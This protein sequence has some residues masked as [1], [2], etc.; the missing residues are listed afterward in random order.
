MK[1]RKGEGEGEGERERGERKRKRERERKK[2]RKRERERERERERKK[3]R[4]RDFVISWFFRHSLSPLSPSMHRIPSIV[5][6]SR[7]KCAGHSC[8]DACC[9]FH[10]SA[11]GKLPMIM[12]RPFICSL[13]LQLPGYSEKEVSMHSSD[14]L[15]PS[16]PNPK[17]YFSSLPQIYWDHS[18]SSPSNLSYS[19][20]L[21]SFIYFS[22]PLDV[23]WT[24][25]VLK[26]R[27]SR[28]LGFSRD[29]GL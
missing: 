29:C 24:V 15:P 27:R 6:H 16:H 8:L 26:P 28:T 23:H 17:P 19:F 13:R 18:F 4:E 14:T 5:F 3:E 20:I 1:E 7:C 10:P 25:L 22:F 2:E 12:S 11:K 9:Y 21:L